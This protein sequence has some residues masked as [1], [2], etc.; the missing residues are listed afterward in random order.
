MVLHIATKQYIAI[1]T[2]QLYNN[3]NGHPGCNIPGL[4]KLFLPLCGPGGPSRP[5]RNT[6]APGGSAQ[7]RHEDSADRQVGHPPRDNPHPLQP[8]GQPTERYPPA[9]SSSPGRLPAE[10]RC[11]P[12]PVSQ[13]STLTLSVTEFTHSHIHPTNTK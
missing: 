13:S 12:Q 4:P 9:A 6:T 8:P 1:L 2:I 10:A 7:R 5:G 11:C 3:H